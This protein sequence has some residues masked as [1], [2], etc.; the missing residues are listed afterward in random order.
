MTEFVITLPI[1]L[2]LMSGLLT[3]TD[4]LI[5]VTAVEIKAYQSTM[6]AAVEMKH[7]DEV[8]S[9]S[10]H[11]DL[12][13]YLQINRAASHAS[14]EF[15][16]PSTFPA[17]EPTARSGFN[18][19]YREHVVASGHTALIDTA[20]STNRMIHA[21]FSGPSPDLSPLFSTGVIGGTQAHQGLSGPFS[22]HALAGDL[23][24]LDHA[25]L[26]H[27]GG[28]TGLDHSRFFFQELMNL[29][30]ASFGNNASL[31]ATAL[32]SRYGVLNRSHSHDIE[33]EY[34][35]FE[36]DFTYAS[37]FSTGVPM[38]FAHET[39]SPALR[40]TR[41]TYLSRIMLESHQVFGG[42]PM[43]RDILRVGSMIDEDGNLIVPNRDIHPCHGGV[44]PAQDIF[45]PLPDDAALFGPRLQY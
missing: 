17:V 36:V 42:C 35:N 33:H 25:Q 16:P 7:T 2:M 5:S 27:L 13:H 37:Y 11:E 21:Q 19:R 32:G 6:N 26:G 28:I 22:H 41:S 8:A 12:N 23:L 18:S 4:V 29:T 38:H 44:L 39:H 30:E 43:Y 10:H 20:T 40:S 34:M 9:P 14:S 15:Q 45:D 24:N 31:H 1:F 3:F